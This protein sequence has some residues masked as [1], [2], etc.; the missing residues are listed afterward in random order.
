MSGK[1]LR[2]AR[3]KANMTLQQVAMRMNTTHATISRYE[4]ERRKID[5]DTMKAFCE[6]YNVSADFILGLPKGLPYPDETEL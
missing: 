1:Q 3:K 5:P 6:L 2:I 4:N